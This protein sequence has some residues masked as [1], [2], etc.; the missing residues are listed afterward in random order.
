MSKF[1][2]ALSLLFCLSLAAQADDAP[3]DHAPDHAPDHD[4]AR[5][6]VEAGRGQPLGRLLNKVAAGHPGKVLQVELE[7][8]SG[9]L[10][11]EVKLLTPDG[12]VQE[13]HYDA[14]TLE[15]VRTETGRRQNRKDGDE[16]GELAQRGRH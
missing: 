5:A 4:R 13:L 15:L 10:F 14:A 9:R 6:A 1:F 8:E 16:G 11:Y 3:P 2:I 12:T 7:D